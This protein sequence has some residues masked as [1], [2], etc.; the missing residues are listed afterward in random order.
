MNLVERRAG[1]TY[2]VSLQDP[3]LVPLETMLQRLDVCYVYVQIY[4]LHS[5]ALEHFPRFY[6]TS[7]SWGS[8]QSA[9]LSQFPLK[10]AE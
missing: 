8:L 9:S 2:G 7:L 1:P 4:G 10:E 5:L 3:D 6:P